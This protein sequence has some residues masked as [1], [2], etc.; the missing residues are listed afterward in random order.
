MKNLILILA[1]V[2]SGCTFQVIDIPVSEYAVG[3]QIV[4][5]VERNETNLIRAGNITFVNRS[6]DVNRDVLV[7]NG[8]HS[9]NE[10]IVRGNDGLP[11]FDFY[12]IGRFQVAF[13]SGK[14]EPMYADRLVGVFRQNQ[15]YTLLISSQSRE[16]GYKKTVCAPQIYHGRHETR[17]FGE[18]YV[19]PVGNNTVE[20]IVSDLVYLPDADVSNRGFSSVP[21]DLDFDSMLRRGIHR[22]MPRK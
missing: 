18:K 13:A 5:P 12:N 22:I 21:A 8:H 2:F 7:F 10:I 16:S 3:L 20:E 17:T 11:T 9:L 15:D 4:V 14:P 6:V 1:S 19:H